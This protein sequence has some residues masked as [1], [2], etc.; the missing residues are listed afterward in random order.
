MPSVFPW[1]PN[2][3]PPIP[4][5]SWQ[6]SAHICGACSSVRSDVGISLG[7]KGAALQREHR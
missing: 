5:R 2:T 6:I 1:P 4:Q 7:L 3:E